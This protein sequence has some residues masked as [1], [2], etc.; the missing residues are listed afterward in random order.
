MVKHNYYNHGIVNS[1]IQN[2]YKKGYFEIVEWVSPVINCPIC[3]YEHILEQNI[4]VHMANV[5]PLT[6]VVSEDHSQCK[7]CSMLLRN[8]TKINWNKHWGTQF[9]KD[10]EH[11][12]HRLME[13]LIGEVKQSCSLEID[14]EE[15]QQVTKVKY[16][17]SMMT[18]DNQDF[19]AAKVNLTRAKKRWNSLKRIATSKMQTLEL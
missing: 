13:K 12:K 5:H 9:C 17:G 19:I 11:R 8:N 6:R 16:L 15:V 14:Q 18:N 3:K 4:K 7:K 10:R 1:S 2:S